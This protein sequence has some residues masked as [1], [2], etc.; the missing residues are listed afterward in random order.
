MTPQVW[1]L[2]G[3]FALGSA[4]G[5]GAAWHLGRAPLRM[6]N[7]DL[8]EAHAEAVRKAVTAAAQRV[9]AAQTRS[10]TL[11]A[12][13]AA[14]L[15]TNATLTQEKTRALQLA[16]NGRACLTG[17]ALRVLNGSPG[18]SVTAAGV[19]APGA[20]AAATDASPAA[21]EGAEPPGIEATDTAVALWIAT[22]GEQYE[23]CRER[24]NALIAWHTPAA[25]APATKSPTEG[26]RP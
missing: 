17:R 3:A 4:A 8:R 21:P 13:L 11:G 26:R 7:A 9:Q 6:E 19:P 22:A 10:D 5:G 20:R 16:T 25:P 2:A 1:L 14:Q 24:L 18:V 23:A 15:A 12:Q